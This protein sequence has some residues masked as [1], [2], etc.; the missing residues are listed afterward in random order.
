MAMILITH[1][2]GLA[3]RWCDRITVME[4]GRV[5][6]QGP[7]EALFEAPAHPYTRK[8][9]AA[10]P[11]RHSTLADLAIGAQPVVERLREQRP[12]TPPLLQLKPRREIL[13]RGGPR[14][15]R[16]FFSDPRPAA[17]SVWWERGSGSGKSTL[18][19]LICR[20]LDPDDGDIVFEGESITRVPAR[21]FHKSPHRGDIQ[22]VFSGSQRQPQSAAHGVRQH[23][24]SA[25]AAR[26]AARRRRAHGARARRGGPGR[27]AVGPSAALPPSAV[28]RP[29]GPRGYRAGDRAAAQ[30]DDSRRADRRSRP[31]PSRRSSCN[32][33]T[34]YGART[35]SACCSSATTSMSCACCATISLCCR[36]KDRGGW[37]QPR[38]LSKAASGLYAR[39]ARRVPYF[40]PQR[41]TPPH[42]LSA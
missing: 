41:R 34:G 30:V 37:T 7:T 14:G 10:S 38:H 6:E 29:E 1:D 9:V 20:L 26:K 24:L 40:D 2:L 13:R 36:R 33:S 22:I 12:G 11:T 19:R 5:V 21:E 18:S 23:R 39:A 15:G 4:A 28:G 8:L 25:A 17:R 3:A 32:C 27:P 35:G 42:A 31:F 16:R